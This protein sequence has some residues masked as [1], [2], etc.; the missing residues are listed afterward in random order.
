LL[1]QIANSSINITAITSNSSAF[2][3]EFGLNVS[4]SE[5]N[6]IRSNMQNRVNLSVME[7]MRNFNIT[8]PRLKGFISAANAFNGRYHN[9][10]TFIISTNGTLMLPFDANEAEGPQGYAIAPG[11]SA[12]FTYNGTISVGNG[13]LVIMPLENQTYS[14][15]ITGEAGAV[16]TSNVIAG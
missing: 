12:T 6:S 14:V 9:M 7:S 11:S 5:F 4:Q 10:L 15:R 16:A 3:K 13:R 2:N 1:S 8:N